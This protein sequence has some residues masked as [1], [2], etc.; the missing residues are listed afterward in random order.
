MTEKP[1]MNKEKMEV[2]LTLLQRMMS[3]PVSYKLNM[4][5]VKPIEA[6]YRELLKI[7]LSLPQE[8]KQLQDIYLKT[9]VAYES[10]HYRI[11]FNWGR[12]NLYDGTE[13]IK[14]AKIEFLDGRPVKV[15]FP[16]VGSETHGKVVQYTFNIILDE[17]PKPVE[18]PKR[19][20]G[21][22]LPSL[23]DVRKQLDATLSLGDIK[24][25]QNGPLNTN[26]V[27]KDKQLVKRGK[28]DNNFIARWLN[29]KKE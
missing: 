19:V 16:H 3:D 20:S 1:T 17:K 6:E 5:T 29:R 11:I 28:A 26:L 7:Y 14:D 21:F 2:R 24:A 23:E 22:K 18:T 4:M 10:N 25:T 9:V 15:S 8:V 27:D 12:W 13:Y